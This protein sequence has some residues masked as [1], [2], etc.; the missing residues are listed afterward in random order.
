MN[1][2]LVLVNKPSVGMS[3]CHGPQGGVYKIIRHVFC[4]GSLQDGRLLPLYAC[5]EL[6][7]FLGRLLGRL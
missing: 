1:G 5:A 3:C 7:A 2:L 6:D 4:Q